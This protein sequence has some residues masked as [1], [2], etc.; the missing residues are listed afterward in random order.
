M[1]LVKHRPQGPLVTPFDEL[2][3]GFFGR[4]LSHFIGSDDMQRSTPRVNITEG[5]EG[6]KLDL[7]ALGAARPGS[8]PPTRRNGPRPA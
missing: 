7:L 2:I 3:N 8:T 5:N 6:F 1:T 4:D